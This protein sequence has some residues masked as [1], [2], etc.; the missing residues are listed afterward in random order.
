MT[1]FEIFLKKLI[2]KTTNDNKSIEW[3]I[4]KISNSLIQYEC[5]INITNDKHIYIIL[6]KRKLNNNESNLYLDSYYTVKNSPVYIDEKEKSKSLKNNLYYKKI[7]TVFLHNNNNLIDLYAKIEYQNFLNSDLKKITFL[8]NI[9]N[10][11]KLNI[12]KWEKQNN[13]YVFY[14]IKNFYDKSVYF[15]L[16]SNNSIIIYLLNKNNF[17][18]YLNSIINTDIKII[19]LLN[20]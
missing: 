13:Y 6:S 8:Q 5:K 15:K 18:I 19:D 1:A 16:Y 11:T 3:D 4:N 9:Y 7:K 17:N 2:K 20:E 14:D 12:I 10:L